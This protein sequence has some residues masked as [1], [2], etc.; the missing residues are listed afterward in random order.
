MTHIEVKKALSLARDIAREAG[1]ILLEK[2][3]SGFEVA[4]KGRVNLVTEADLA[5]EKFIIERIREAYPEHG[6]L[7]EETGSSRVDSPVRWVI[8]PLDG[9]TNYAHGYPFYCVS[10]GLEIERKLEA[11]V[12]YNP[13]SD[14]CFTAVRGGGAFLNGNP[15]GVSSRNELEDCLF[16]TG[17]SYQDEEILTNLSLFNRV[18]VKARSVRRDGA[19]ALDLCFVACGRFDGFW[20]LSLHPW[21]VAAGGLILEEAG[22]KYSRFDGSPATIYD[23]EILATNGRVHGAIS[24]LLREG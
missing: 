20:E 23:R 8:D 6:I 4:K 17:F 7:A 9:T 24:K 13:V 2:S 16:C 10:I 22:G 21:D 15:I 5:S 14:E 1:E 18:M 11:G 12:V 3:E 19:A